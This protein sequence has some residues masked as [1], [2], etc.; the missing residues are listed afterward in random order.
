MLRPSTIS[1]PTI[2]PMRAVVHRPISKL[3]TRHVSLLPT[4]HEVV[5]TTHA[6]ECVRGNGSSLLI[7]AV[8]GSVHNQGLEDGGG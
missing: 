2:D 1:H 7:N 8:V 3:G 6:D 4:D 5:L